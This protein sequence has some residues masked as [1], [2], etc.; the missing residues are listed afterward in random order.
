MHDRLRF[1]ESM[2]VLN[3]KLTDLVFCYDLDGQSAFKIAFSIEAM[4]H[5]NVAVLDGGLQN[6]IRM[7]FPI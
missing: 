3:V 5:K 1:I 4:G 6:W 7:Q 2:K